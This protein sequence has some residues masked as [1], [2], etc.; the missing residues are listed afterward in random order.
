MEIP[1]AAVA[2]AGDSATVVVKRAPFEPLD[3]PLLARSDL[4]VTNEHEAASCWDARSA[5]RAARSPQVAGMLALGPAA[6][7]ITLGATGA[8]VASARGQLHVPAPR[9]TPVDTTGDAFAGSL[10]ARLAAGIPLER[11]VEFAV[12]VGSATTEH[13]GPLPR[14]PT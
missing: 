12:A 10:S 5:I 14:L 7:V 4:I 6:A 8:A 1:L 3:G 9:A 13:R 11:A 2:A